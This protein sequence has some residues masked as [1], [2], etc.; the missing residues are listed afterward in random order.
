MTRAALYALYKDDWAHADAIEDVS[1]T[2][3]GAAAVNS[4][5]ATRGEIAKS[6]IRFMGQEFLD[7]GCDTVM[8]IWDA[9][10]T[11]PDR[12]AGD[13]SLLVDAAGN[14]YTVEFARQVSF[15]T[16]WF[17]GLKLQA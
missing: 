15:D 6:Q 2:P 17:L 11:G 1:W 13:K 3:R 4:I 16:Q 8:V 5:K 9:T 14:R 12:P 10:I 7:M